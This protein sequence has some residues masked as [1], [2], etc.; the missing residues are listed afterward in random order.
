MDRKRLPAREWRA[1]QA[2]AEV[3][4]SR[5]IRAQTALL[6][7]PDLADTAA[8]KKQS[9][10]RHDP[11][12][13]DMRFIRPAS[14]KARDSAAHDRG[15]SQNLPGA[16]RN[17][18]FVHSMSYLHCPVCSRAFN[19]AQHPA[20]PYC[21]VAATPVDPVDDLVAAAESLARALAHATPAQR[22]AAATR[23]RLP[24]L[25][26]AT[27]VLVETAAL[28]ASRVALAPAP[29][30]AGPRR[31]RWLAALAVAALDRLAPHAPRRLLRA[32]HAGVKALAA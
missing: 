10:L 23:V 3:V 6:L 13:P 14:D 7:R 16:R 21:P 24:D 31:S 32:V 27:P 28:R 25:S 11:R 17:C 8:F 20:C 29:Q 15:P 9:A 22:A 1:R 19:L 18:T 12:N 4:E 5:A 2:N 26:P 30:L